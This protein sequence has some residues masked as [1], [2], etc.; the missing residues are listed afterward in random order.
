[1]SDSSPFSL[2]PPTDP[3]LLVFSACASHPISL[4]VIQ[5]S[6]TLKPAARPRTARSL[7]STLP[8]A[9]LSVYLNACLPACLLTADADVAA[10][11]IADAHR[12]FSEW[13]LSLVAFGEGAG[14]TKS[15]AYVFSVPV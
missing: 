15:I 13:L 10:V 14:A 9:S 11:A 1:V 3:V 8:S 2:P 4:N 6:V 12:F 7:N 5:R